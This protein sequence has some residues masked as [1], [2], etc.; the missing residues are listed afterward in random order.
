MPDGEVEDVRLLLVD[1]PEVHGGVE[2]YGPEATEFVRALLPEGTVVRLERDATDRD[3][4]GR[5]LRYVH[6]PDGSM[7]NERLAAEG[8]AEFNAYDGA[9]VRHAERIEAAE[10]R[11]RASRAGLWGACRAL[12]P[13]GDECDPAYVNLCIP[14]PPPDLDCA[15]LRDAMREAGVDVVRLAP[16]GADSHRLDGNDDGLACGVE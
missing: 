16:D 3:F 9:N 5:L 11:A 4:F 6:L 15:D 13:L 10:A 2:C 12:S 7:L 8:F 1:T 14:P